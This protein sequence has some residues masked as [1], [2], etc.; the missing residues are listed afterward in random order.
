MEKKTG[1]R[2]AISDI[3]GCAHTFIALLEKISFS[4]DDTLY[5]LGDSISRGKRSKKVIKTITSLQQEG[6]SV[7]P[8]RGNHEQFIISALHRNVHEDFIKI[9][10][11]LKL[12]WLINKETGLIKEKYISFFSDLPFYY[13]LAPVYLSHAGFDFSKSDFLENTYAMLYQR[14][15]QNQENIPDNILVI[16]GHTPISLQ[17][18]QR[19]IDSV[20]PIITIDNG[21][22]YATN[23][24]NWGNM[25]CID[26]DSRDIF[27][28]KNIEHTTIVSTPELN[29]I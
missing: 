22:V 27:I 15:I 26:I 16:H 17:K 2:Y 23:S 18:I 6:Y 7:Y 1:K 5:I 3:H 19:S 25:I 12:Q 10:K 9:C 20:A 13:T 4:I 21:C 14:E 29:N 24:Q 11:R 28:Q 8:L